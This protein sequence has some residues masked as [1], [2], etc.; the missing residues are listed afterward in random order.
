M[1][2]I[3]VGKIFYCRTVRVL[4]FY[5]WYCGSACAVICI[6]CRIG[7][8]TVPCGEPVET[9]REDKSAAW[10]QTLW[11]WLTR[12]STIQRISLGLTSSF[13]SLLAMR[14]RMVSKAEEN[15]L[16]RIRTNE[17]VFWRWVY[18]HCA[19]EWV[20]HLQCFCCACMWTGM[21][22]NGASCVSWVGEGWYIQNI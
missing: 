13:K 18:M 11:E 10:W 3:W 6:E 16:K 20:L 17:P 8:W 9:E 12:K 19:K 14:C 2:R 5:D 7:N 4:N 21:G 1:N 22:L 15:L